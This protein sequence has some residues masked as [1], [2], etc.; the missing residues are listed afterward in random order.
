MPAVLVTAAVE[1]PAGARRLVDHLARFFRSR[2][3]VAA[4]DRLLVAVSGGADSTALLWGMTR[5]ARQNDLEIHA[6]H[7]DHGLD[8]GSGARAAA[9][10]RLCARLEVPL[11]AGRRQVAGRRRAGESLEAAARRVRYRFLERRRVALDARWVLTAH[12]ADDQAETLLL[13]CLYGSGLAGLAGIAER[14]DRIVR[15]FLELPRSE[16]QAAVEAAGLQPIEDPTNDDLSVPRNLIRHRLIPALEPR[17]PSLTADLQAVAR[18]ARGARRRLDGIVEAQTG[19]DVEDG[20]VSLDREAL[21][22]LPDALWPF[23]LARACRMAGLR[24]PP[25]RDARR[26]LQRQLAAGSQVGCDQGDGWRWRSRDGRLRLEPSS[27]A[28]EPLPFCRTF[29]APGEV[30]VPELGIRLRLRRSALEPWMLLGAADRTGLALRLRPGET[31]TVRSRRPGD[32]LK[33]LGCDYRRRLKEVL[34]DRRV[35]RR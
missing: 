20:R 26:E 32:R 35:P 3:W 14:R 6:A 34:I 12:H 22:A 11:H 5:L 23:A 16:I 33:P 31:V 2:P 28:E 8:A 9:V 25:G 30:E 10:A 24:Y 29:Q 7:L 1:P 15:P 27:G 19:M 13:R 18:V 17:W 21:A 4:A